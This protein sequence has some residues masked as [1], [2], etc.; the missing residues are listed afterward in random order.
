MDEL[1]EKIRVEIRVAERTDEAFIAQ[2]GRAAF[3]EYSPHSARETSSM[4]QRG[5]T[6]VA[7]L[8]GAPVGFVVL[9][10][11][12]EGSMHVSAIAVVTDARGSGIG[13]RLL[14][15]A[16]MAARG[17]GAGEVTLVTADANLGALELFLRSGYQRTRRADRYYARG[18]GAVWLRKR[19]A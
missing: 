15:T 9:D 3:A 17:R 14:G 10:A 11:L 5:T 4:A 7:F 18:Q 13:K 16:E 1:R 6:W 8:D 19:L 2:L 12:R